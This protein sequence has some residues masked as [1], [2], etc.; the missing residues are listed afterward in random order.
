[1]TSACGPTP[2]A[3]QRSL[4][5]NASR[6]RRLWSLRSARGA[7]NW[8]RGT[9]LYRTPTTLEQACGLGL[10]RV[11]GI[12]RGGSS[13]QPTTHGTS[14]RATQLHE[15]PRDTEDAVRA[16][17]VKRQEWLTRAG[18]ISGSSCG[19]RSSALSSALPPSSP[20]SSIG[21]AGVVGHGHRGTGIVPFDASLKIPP[22][23]GFWIFD[24][25]LASPR[26]GTRSCGSTTRRTS[27]TYRRVWETLQESAVYGA[28]A[29]NVINAA[30]RALSSR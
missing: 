1:M 2:A 6:L 23:N 7:V 17:R 29:H 10:P 21:L 18:R 8:P 26:T 19:R 22:A 25:R 11:G 12:S 27:V 13:R 16:R 24:E 3:S 14:S 28:D 30:R 5:E 9:G 4:Q 20:P 15:S